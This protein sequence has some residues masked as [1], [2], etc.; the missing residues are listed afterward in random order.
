VARRTSSAAKRSAS[1]PRL[2][3]DASRHN[4]KQ[5]GEEQVSSPTGFDATHVCCHFVRHSVVG[6]TE[7]SHG[8]PI[9][10]EASAR[11]RTRSSLMSDPER[12]RH[13]PSSERC[14]GGRRPQPGRLLVRHRC[15]SDRLTAAPCGCGS[16][17]VRNSGVSERRYG[18]VSPAHCCAG[19]PSEPGRARFRASGSSK[20]VRVRWR[21]RR[22]IRSLAR[23]FRP[24]VRSP[25]CSSWRLT[26]PRVLV[27]SSSSL[28]WLT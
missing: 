22:T 5:G 14:G 4:Q 18:R 11:K 16:L 24:L 13:A 7:Q 15:T 21:R 2:D 6:Q 9:Y 26:C 12:R 27:S 10:A 1:A 28:H 23:A 25:R 19:L 17:K 20:L 3:S 8:G